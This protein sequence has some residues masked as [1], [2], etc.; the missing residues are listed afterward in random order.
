MTPARFQFL[1]E[2]VGRLLPLGDAADVLALM[3]VA[4]DE[5]GVDYEPLSREAQLRLFKAGNELRSLL[6]RARS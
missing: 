6:L 1:Q 3:E 4:A 2:A 5:G